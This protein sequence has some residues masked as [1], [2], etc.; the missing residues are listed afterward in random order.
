MHWLV[1]SRHHAKVGVDPVDICQGDINARQGGFAQYAKACGMALALGH[2][3]GDRRSTYNEAKYLPFLQTHQ[4][5]L[6]QSAVCYAE[7]VKQDWQWLLSQEQQLSGKPH[8]Y[9]T[10]DLP[11]PL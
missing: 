2:L 1:R 4:L 3:R 6:Q 5:N 9:I 8:E 10:Q 7:Q 11:H